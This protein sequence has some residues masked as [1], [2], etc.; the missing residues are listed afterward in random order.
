MAGLLCLKTG[1]A[2]GFAIY[3]TILG[4]FCPVAP[5]WYRRGSASSQSNFSSK[6]DLS[7]INLSN[8]PGLRGAIGSRSQPIGRF[9]SGIPASLRPEETTTGILG[10]C[11]REG[12]LNLP[13]G[14]RGLLRIA[15][16][17][18]QS[19]PLAVSHI[20]GCSPD[21]AQNL[22]NTLAGIGVVDLRRSRRFRRSR[23]TLSPPTYCSPCLSS[24]TP[25]AMP[26]ISMTPSRG[27][28]T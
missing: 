25:S 26:W 10:Q 9:D 15:A 5:E 8:T 21:S 23:T 22:G 17:R 2:M 19:I 7:R 28:M 11:R 4:C 16:I 14:T 18:R 6:M 20:L 3:R 1:W 13:A 12:H 24:S 27:G